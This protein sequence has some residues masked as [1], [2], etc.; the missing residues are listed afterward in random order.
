V[1]GTN[2]S[3][4]K[5]WDVN[6]FGHEGADRTAYFYR[7]DYDYLDV[8]G[9]ALQAGRNFSRDVSSDIKQAVIVN[10]TLVQEFGWQEPVIGRR[11]SGWNEKN[12]PGG[13]MVIG[14][15]KDYHFLSLHEPVKPV[16]LMLDP[17]WP[18]AYVLARV[19]ADCAEYALRV[20]FCERGRAAA[21]RNGFALAKNHH[22]ECHVRRRT[23]QYGI[24]RPGHARRRQPHQRNW[25]SQSSRCLDHQYCPIIVD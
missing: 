21:I 23:R 4:N 17:E 15:A 24:V 22:L 1:T 12:V 5:G 13:P 16:I 19:N 2:A 3:F 7:V 6:R 14:V 20:C 10:E 11:L 18:I 25:Y 9:I 8:L